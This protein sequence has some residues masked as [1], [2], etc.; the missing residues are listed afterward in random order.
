MLHPNRECVECVSACVCDSAEHESHR[1]EKPMLL[2]VLSF[3]EERE[4]DDIR[5]YGY[6][7][8]SVVD[9]RCSWFAGRMML[10]PLYEI[11]F[12]RAAP[13]HGLLCPRKRVNTAGI[14]SR[15]TSE[16]GS[17]EAGTNY[18]FVS[19]MPSKMSFASPSTV[20]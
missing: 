13:E 1:P 6:V 7:S 19:M 3:G 8:Q 20:W 14:P 5:T 12:V 2:A 15:D 9:H 11:L 4:G 18:L 16:R 17:Q 10:W